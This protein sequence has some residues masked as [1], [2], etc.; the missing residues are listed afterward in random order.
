[1][2]TYPIKNSNGFIFAFEIENTFISLHRIAKLLRSSSNVS[3]VRVRTFF[4]FS[5]IVIR[6]LYKKHEFV[7]WEPYGDNSRYWIGPEDDNYK[8]Y[9]LDQ[10]QTIFQ[11]Y[12]PI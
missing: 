4:S 7:V 3:N 6:F 1:M 2:K 11:N 10:L 8:D 9:T 5:D 12:N